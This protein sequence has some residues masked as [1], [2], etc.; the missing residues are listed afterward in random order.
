MV[1]SPGGKLVAQ[2][3]EPMRVTERIEP[4]AITNPKPGVCL[5]EF[6]LHRHA[7][8]GASRQAIGYPLRC[9]RR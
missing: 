3:L 8:G 6:G 2:M 7:I 1:S 9:T 5:V 4:V